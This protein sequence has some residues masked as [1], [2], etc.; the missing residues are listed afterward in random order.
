MVQVNQ[1]LWSCVFH[2]L[3]HLQMISMKWLLGINCS[4]DGSRYELSAD[5]D[6]K[7]YSFI[8]DGEQLNQSRTITVQDTLVEQHFGY[9][10][11]IH[12][13][14]TLKLKF[15][16][17]TA[18]GRSDAISKI[19]NEDFQYAYVKYKEWSKQHSASVSVK[20]F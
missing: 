3:R 16:Q 11:F 2:L 15:T 5:Y 19:S 4:V 12:S 1:A 6:K 9:T 20:K 7:K 13:I 10:R 8:K 17:M 18:Q 14:L